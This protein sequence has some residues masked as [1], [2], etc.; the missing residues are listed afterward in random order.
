MSLKDHFGIRTVRGT[1]QISV[2][3]VLFVAMVLILIGLFVAIW[4][5][6]RKPDPGF[7]VTDRGGMEDLLPSIAGLTHGDVQSGNHIEIVQNGEFFDRLISDIENAKESVHFE[8]FLWHEGEIG[9][10]LAGAF[11]RKARE[12][13]EVRV[14][15]DASGTRPMEDEVEQLMRDAGCKVEKFHKFNLANLG[16]INNRT[17]RKITVIDGRI[18]YTGGHCIA[19]EWTGAARNR[20]EYRDTSIRIRGPVVGRLQSAFVE[21]WL[22]STGEAPTGDKYF[23]EIPP[24]GDMDAHLVYTTPSGSGSS[25]EILYHLAIIGADRE[26]I[27][28]NPYFLPDPSVIEELAAAVA[29]GVEVFVMLPSVEATDNAIVQHASHHRF[30]ALLE[31][32]I[33]IF[34]YDRTL[35]HQKVMIV[36]GIWSSVGSTNFDDRSLEINDEISLGILDR[37][38]AQELRKA[39]EEDLRHSRELELDVWNDRGLW[40]RLIDGVTFLGNE[41]L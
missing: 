8:T 4:S 32:G 36:D 21:N 29:R 27:I 5:I 25:V 7:H 24:A 14:L 41:Q 3:L 11:A 30:G 28:Q 37:G 26:I 12:G 10:R 9:R 13:V 1:T 31:K 34:E 2:P 40:H 15:L 20:K 16:R 33:R 35:L 19:P 23:P 18:A 22:E 39:W 17:H 38:I 6:K